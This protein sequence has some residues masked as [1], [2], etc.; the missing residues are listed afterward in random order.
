MRFPE[1]YLKGDVLE[2]DIHRFVEDWHE[3]HDGGGIELHEYLGM[4]WEEY[5][6]WVATPAAL[7][8]ILA[9]RKRGSLSVSRSSEVTARARSG[10]EA[11]KV[12]A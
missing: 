3:G 11:T 8:F 12:Q 4:S 10:E 7:S 9:P 1:L 2:E 5:G 6:V